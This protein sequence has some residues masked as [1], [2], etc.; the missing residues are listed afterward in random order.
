MKLIASA[1]SACGM[2]VENQ[3]SF[4]INDK[5]FQQSECQR[6]TGQMI[7]HKQKFLIDS[8]SEPLLFAVADGVTCSRYGGIASID[9]LSALATEINSWKDSASIKNVNE[10]IYAYYKGS[11]ATTLS[12][13]YIENTTLHIYNVGDSPIYLFRKNE[14]IPMY[15][16]ETKAQWKRMNGFPEEMITVRD[17]HTLINYIGQEVLYNVVETISELQ[18]DDIW[19]IATDGLMFDESLKEFVQTVYREKSGKNFAELIINKMKEDNKI[20]DNISIITLGVF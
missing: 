8:S 6:K 5:V 10:K 4:L 9:A 19:F 1:A 18:A 12:C 2:R 14:L 13:I 17:H 11:A 20:D 7:K 15:T 16:P 3:D